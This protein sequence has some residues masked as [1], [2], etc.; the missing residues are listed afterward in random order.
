MKQKKLQNE[1]SVSVAASFLGGEGAS[2]NG[3]I[4][5]C[6]RNIPLVITVTLTALFVYGAA[7][8]NTAVIG[9]IA[10]YLADPDYY[11]LE[12]FKSG[13]WAALLLTK[14]FFIKES[15]IYASNF[16]SV[17]SIWL[18]SL[19]FPYF[20][21]VFTRNT[22]RRN[23]LIPLALIVMT[24]SVW[25]Q[26]FQFFWQNKIQTLFIC[27]ALTAV[28][29]LFDGFLT[30]RKIKILIGFIITAFSF[31]LYQP[32]V[33][34]FICIVFIFFVLLEDNTSFDAKD[35]LN[36]CIKLI[37]VFIAAFAFFLISDKIAQF[38]FNVRESGYVS[39]KMIWNK[40]S[41]KSIISGILAQIYVLTIGGIPFVHSIFSPMMPNMYGSDFDTFNRPISDTVLATSQSVGNIL[42]L[43][44]AIAFLV[45]ICINAAKRLPKTR[46]LLYTLAGFGIPLSVLLLTIV[47][48]EVIGTRILYS[49]PFAAA[50]M[51]YYVSYRQKT[52][53]RRVFYCMILGTA[54]YQAQ[55]S[56]N[57]LEASSRVSEMD[58]KIT[59]DLAARIRSVLPEDDRLPVVFIGNIEHPFDSQLFRVNEIGRSAFEL[60]STTYME[61]ITERALM[62]MDVYGFH[63]DAPL[64]EQILEAYEASFDMPGYPANGCVK[65]LDDLIVVKMGE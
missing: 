53:L 54:F 24:Y 58:A 4:D 44:A 55:I 60:W 14:L 47:S 34:L 16:I 1:M 40:Y 26:Y 37:I 23:G 50:F 33:P 52:F 28:Y 21:A 10:G 2:F 49:L 51:F 39:S 30:R 42:L 62:V 22:G 45:I 41:V 64:P 27:L 57:L 35:Y 43:P 48:G 13:R 61:H 59:F 15:G 3:F 63:Y 36:L 17:L 31:C 25:P 56:G 18:F 19:L 12:H 46:R 9:D 29:L 6:K 11:K 32:F 7:V 5:F 8:F 65:K 38:M 20:I